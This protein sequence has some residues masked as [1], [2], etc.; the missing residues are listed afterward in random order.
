M[1]RVRER[2]LPRNQ[3]KMTDVTCSQI[4]LLRVNLELIQYSPQSQFIDN[5][6]VSVMCNYYFL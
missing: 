5:E 2:V 1:M 6:F 3:E 4:H